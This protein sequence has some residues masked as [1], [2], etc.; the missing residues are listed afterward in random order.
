MAGL[1]ALTLTAC[2]GSKA[3]YPETDRSTGQR[4]MVDP[5]NPPERKGLFGPGGLS[6]LG[7]DKSKEDA[8]A[9]GVGVNSFLWRASLDTIAFMP[10]TS[11]DPFGGV[12]LSDWY[13]PP[14][15]PDERFKANVYILGKGLRADGIKVAVFRQTRDARGTWTE[16]PV[17]ARMAS[18]MENI[19][20]TRARQLRLAVLEK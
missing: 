11:A 4:V 7:D 14:G 16:A 5:A 10:L 1:L 18:D 15:A 2:E 9:T 19:I 20:L 3:V 17:N 8:G 13:S 12:I 6:L